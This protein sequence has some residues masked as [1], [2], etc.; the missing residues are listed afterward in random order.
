MKSKCQASL[1]VVIDLEQYR[2]WL[3]QTLKQFVDNQDNEEIENI[4]LSDDSYVDLEFILY[5]EPM[6]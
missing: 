1:V 5:G 4:A 6:G 3:I 2:Q